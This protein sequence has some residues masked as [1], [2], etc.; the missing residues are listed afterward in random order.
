MFRM[1]VSEP[2]F[3]LNNTFRMKASEPIDVA[4]AMKAAS[5]RQLGNYL[6]LVRPKMPSE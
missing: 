6:F 2:R 4:I 1:K 5:P 3:N